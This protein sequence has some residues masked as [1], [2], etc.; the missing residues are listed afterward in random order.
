[1]GATAEGS[2]AAQNIKFSGPPVLIIKDYQTLVCAPCFGGGVTG[3]V[4]SRISAIFPPISANL[5]TEI[6][7]FRYP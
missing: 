6:G 7:Y 4:Q 3:G 1:M 5:Q 2:G